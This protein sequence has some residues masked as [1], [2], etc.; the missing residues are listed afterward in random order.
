MLSKNQLG[1]FYMF[2][3]I[4]A[5]SFMDVIVKWSSDYPI[6]Q[7]MFFRGLFGILPIIFL[8][9]KTR[10]RDFY[11]TNRQ[12]L[13]LIRCCSGLIALAAIFLALRNLPLATVTSISF[14]APIFTTLLSI[15]LLSEKVGV[16]RWAA[17]FV[18]FIGVL[19]ITQPGFSSLNIYYLFPI[20]F[21]IGMSYVAITIR[22]L[23]ST[24]PVW[25]IS[26]FFS[27]AITIVGVLSIPFGWI[28]PTFNDFLLLCTI[29]LL[30]G[31][32]NLLL[33]Q[34]YKLSEVSLVTPLK[35]LGLIFA[36]SFGYFIWDEIPTIKTLM[37]ASLVIISS[38][39]IFRREIYLNKQVTVSR[40]E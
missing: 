22:K 20:I 23:S 15:F 29:G 5:F 19:V 9:P 4:C 32:A 38:I 10:F 28:M 17:V 8:V 13:H 3:S 30:G 21:C 12:G 40:N 34:S 39:I 11:K 18:G 35:Y 25:L 6:G 16:Y 31:T 1:F 24:E 14:A 26:F 33:S 7:V 27:F 2:L 37:G 36:I